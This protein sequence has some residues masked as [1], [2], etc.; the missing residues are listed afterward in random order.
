MSL[1][2]ITAVN[3][4]CKIG[5]I[6]WENRSHFSTP[7]DVSCNNTILNKNNE[8]VTHVKKQMCVK[9]SDNLC[10]FLSCA[11]KITNK[12]LHAKCKLHRRCRN[13]VM[14]CKNYMVYIA[15]VMQVIHQKMLN[16]Q[17]LCNCYWQMVISIT[18]TAKKNKSTTVLQLTGNLC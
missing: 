18:A 16:K 2:K 11:A 1:T 15:R 5:K 7:A 14:C 9:V 6:S 8:Y 3:L 4:P 10:R 13:I 12:M 17:H